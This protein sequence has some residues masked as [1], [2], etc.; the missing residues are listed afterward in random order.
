MLTHKAAREPITR[1]ART[2]CAIVIVGSTNAYDRLTSEIRPLTSLT[3]RKSRAAAAFAPR[4]R[5]IEPGWR[6]R[7]TLAT[8]IDQLLHDGAVKPAIQRG[9]IGALTYPSSCASC[10]RFDELG[11]RPNT[12][13][14]PTME[15]C[16]CILSELSA[17]KAAEHPRNLFPQLARS[18]IMTC[19]VLQPGS[20]RIDRRRMPDD[21]LS[22][23]SKHIH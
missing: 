9:S 4:E 6:A 10:F 20:S 11:S 19:S 15:D 16:Q 8:A 17:S 21:L 5:A 1:F 14:R 2:G 3:Y 7:E 12:L 18:R 13:I 22:N 23:G